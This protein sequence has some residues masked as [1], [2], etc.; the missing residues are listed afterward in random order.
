MEHK[1]FKILGDF[2]LKRITIDEATDKLLILHSV[3]G[4]SELLKCF[5]PKDT[6]ICNNPITSEAC[7]KCKYL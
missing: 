1:I 7:S 3:V 5:I 2:K 4:R 6:A